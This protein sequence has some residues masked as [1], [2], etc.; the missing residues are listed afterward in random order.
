MIELPV[1]KPFP[2]QLLLNYLSF[3]CIPNFESIENDCY[4]RIHKGNKIT[5][6]YDKSRDLLQ[7]QPDIEIENTEDVIRRVLRIFRPN[8]S[9]GAIFAKLSPQLPIV[10]KSIGFRPLGCWDPFE[11]CVRTIIGQQVTVAAANTI[12]QRLVD[13]CGKLT[14]ELIQSIKLDNMGMPGRRVQCIVDLA[15]A[16]LEDEIDLSQPWPELNRTLAKLPG[17]GPWT[18]GYLAIRL[19]LDDDAFPETDVGLIRASGVDNAKVLLQ[20]A[21]SWRPYRAYAAVCLWSLE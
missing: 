19:G 7:I 11:L 18:R 2:W 9:T 21:E 8:L 16:I 14:P 17:I 6:S 5:V 1:V 13:R 4:Q 20:Q 3:R 10:Y 15:K 12:M